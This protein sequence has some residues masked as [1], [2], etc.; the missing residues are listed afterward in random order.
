MAVT[1]T[2]DS[3]LGV[4]SKPDTSSTAGTVT[5]SGLQASVIALTTAQT[6]S[7]AQAGAFTF[8][9]GGVPVVYVMPLASSCPGAVF[10]FRNATAQANA[11]TCSQEAAGTKAFTDGTSNGS[12]LAVANVLDSS[13]SLLSDGRSFLVLGNSGSLAFSGT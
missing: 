13:V 6:L 12:K 10:T 3:T 5:I 2:I 11:L 8:G 1:T 9:N 7:A 4:V